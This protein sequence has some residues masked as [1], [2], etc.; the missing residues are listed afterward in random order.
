VSQH[1]SRIIPA[2]LL[3]QGLV[4]ALNSFA[5]AAASA[6]RASDVQS[7]FTQMWS[8]S[9]LSSFWDEPPREAD[10][11]SALGESRCYGAGPTD[12]LQT[13]RDVT[14]LGRREPRVRV[15]G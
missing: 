12:A 14:Q 10:C 11:W 8:D 5:E 6:S 1:R 2:G 13:R 4:A 7:A 9:D 3:G 15:E